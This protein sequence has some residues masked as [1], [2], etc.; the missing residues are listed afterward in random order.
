MDPGD[1]AT[2]SWSGETPGAGLKLKCWRREAMKVK[3]SILAKDSPRQALGP[4]GGEE[5][6]HRSYSS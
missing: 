3:S 5:L 1:G 4:A 2:R 6:E